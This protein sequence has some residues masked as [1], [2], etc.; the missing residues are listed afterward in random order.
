MNGVE[1]LLPPNFPHSEHLELLRCHE[2]SWHHSH[3]SISTERQR[4]PLLDHAACFILQGGYLI[5]ECL[6]ESR[7]GYTDLCSAAR[8]KELRWVHVMFRVAAVQF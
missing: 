8:N 3:L 2:E 4:V 6:R 7:Y 1:D 5:Y